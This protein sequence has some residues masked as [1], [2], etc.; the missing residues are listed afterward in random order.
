MKF[1]ILVML[2]LSA[3]FITAES[4]LDPREIDLQSNLLQV[5]EQTNVPLKKIIFYLGLDESTLPSQTLSELQISAEQLKLAL[6]NYHNSSKSFYGSI[7]LVG[8]SIVFISLMIVGLFISSL[9]HLDRS[10]KTK[11]KT[12]EAKM[13]APEHISSNAIIAAITAIYLHEAEAEEKNRLLLT[14]TRSRLSMWS[15]A[16]LVE[17]RFIDN[18]RGR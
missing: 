12:R 3:V 13:T 14:W 11:P 15:A 16:N 7:V 2:L 1:F 17:S 18:K 9:Q 6:Q 4:S 5:S 8:M 10:K